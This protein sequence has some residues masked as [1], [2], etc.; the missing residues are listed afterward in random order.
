MNNFKKLLPYLIFFSLVAVILY[1][2][3]AFK[4]YS[5]GNVGI[6][7]TTEP[8]SKLEVA[9]RIKDET[10]FVTPV[11]SMIAYCGLLAPA[12]W[13]LC[14]GKT[15]GDAT[16]GA[17]YAGDIYH[18]LYDALQGTFGGT[19]NWIDHGKVNLPDMRGIFPKGAGVTTRTAG[20]DAN[21]AAYGA[22][23]TATLGSYYTDHMQGHKH[24]L[25]LGTGSGAID[26]V[27]TGSYNSVN[28]LSSIHTNANINIPQN[29]GTNGS[30]RTG[31]TTEPQSLA[32]NYIIKY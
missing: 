30:P 3:E 14:D 27:N 16:S 5:S 23:N 1:A 18:N 8:T 20:V 10:G 19:Y 25:N 15:V 2:A 26:G 21:G 6:G 22:N 12:G 17:D 31:F 11:G 24:S 29:D 4:V 28:T 32:V 7:T 13:K 9:G